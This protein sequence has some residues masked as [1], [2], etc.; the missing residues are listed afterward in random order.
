VG[1]L[2]G[3]ADGVAVGSAILDAIAHA[4]DA[5]RPLALRTFV[6]SLR[7]AGSFS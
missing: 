5:T 3:V 7:D 4:P 6:K 1:A 2:R